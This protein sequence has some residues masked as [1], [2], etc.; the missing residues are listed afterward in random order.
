VTNDS[1]HLH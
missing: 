1:S